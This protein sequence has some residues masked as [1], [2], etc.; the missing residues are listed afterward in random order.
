MPNAMGT[1]S[2]SLVM[3][4]FNGF[5]HLPALWESL[6]PH[7]DGSTEL[8]IIDDG[9]S[10]NICD[11]LPGAKTHESVQIFRNS[12]PHGI[13]QAVNKGLAVAGG[14]YLF[15]MNSDLILKA[16]TLSLLVKALQADPSIGMVSSKLIYPQTARVQHVGLAYSETNHF[17]VFRHA[18]EN[19]PLA[20]RRREVQALA[21]ALCC[22]PREI[23]QELGGVDEGYF[24]SY[25]DLA[26]SFRISRL[27]KKLV[28]EPASVAYHWERQ[29]GAI[30]GVLR[31]DN[32]A[33]LWRDWG[34]EIR[35]DI[36][37]YLKEAIGFF[38]EAH[39]DARAPEYTLVNL[40]RGR[41]AEKIVTLLSSCEESFSVGAVWELGSRDKDT[42]QLWLP[43]MLP[44]EGIR[45]P[46]PFI[47]LVDEYPQLAE[48]A[49]WFNLRREFVGDEVLI[50]HNANVL[51]ALESV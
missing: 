37:D 14:D 48:N 42:Y 34:G 36:L 3:P 25:E 21:T 39:P 1:I 40:S 46:R 51:S 49:Y 2:R 6:A 38:K 33:R 20:C 23:Y 16:D 18:P 47:Y 32:V 41:E 29:S 19:H 30:R 35:P 27:Q 43:Q 24:N 15:I 12:R 17:H 5:G 11:V 26:Y 45:H 28:V 50:D 31:K 44:I 4:I 7:L 13:S 9:S 8:I 22:M 10:R